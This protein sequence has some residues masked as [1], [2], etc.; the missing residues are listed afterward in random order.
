MPP[1]CGTPKKDEEEEEGGM[2]P[3]ELVDTL[4]RLEGVTSELV[5][6]TI[7]PSFVTQMVL[8]VCSTGDLSLSVSDC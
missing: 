1:V 5:P 6:A 4:R 8:Q 7:E 2:L 3:R